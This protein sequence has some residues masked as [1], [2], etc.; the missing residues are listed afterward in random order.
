MHRIAASILAAG[1]IA[2]TGAASAQN[3][4][5][6]SPA[7]DRYA[8]ADAPYY[9][10]ARVLRVDPVLPSGYRP[11]RASSN[12]CYSEDGYYTDN[13]NDGRYDD[14]YSDRN[15]ESG[16]RYES[17]DGD[18]RR[19]GRYGNEYGTQTGRNVA[20]VIGGIVGAA[21]G[22][23]VGGGSARY[24][25]AAVGSMVGGM[26]G[27]EV[28]ETT[29][30]NRQPKHARVTVCDPVSEGDYAR[31]PALTNEVTAYDVTYE[32]A[33]REYVTRTSYHPGDRIRVRVDIRPE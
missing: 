29:Q 23:K 19:N 33:D 8:E 17:R 11:T 28:Y 14:R 26:A 15:D 24:A 7:D 22:S 12:E 1:L 6:P 3:A 27:R 2:A 9:D 10:Y 30:R 20:T 18:D 4:G 25:T 5:Y 13:G 31:Y 21:L 16:S 32:Y